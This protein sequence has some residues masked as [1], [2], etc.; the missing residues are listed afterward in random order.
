MPDSAKN[1]MSQQG[2]VLAVGP[3]QEVV[4]EGDHIIY[5]PFVQNPFRHLGREYLHVEMRHIVGRLNLAGEL[6]PHPWDVVIRPEFQSAG[7]PVLRGLLWVPEQ[8]FDVNV[9][10]TGTVI[11]VGAV[12]ESVRAGDR[13]LYPPEAGSEVG[14]RKV[15]YV[16]NHREILAVL[17]T[18]KRIN[19]QVTPASWQPPRG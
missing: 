13:V 4:C 16:I 11:T 1:P 3:H 18:R 14:L 8:V 2:I 7:R 9:P 12:V 6:V 15:W 17:K 10:C 19:V 5:H